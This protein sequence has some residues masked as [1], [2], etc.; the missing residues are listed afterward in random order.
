MVAAG[1]VRALRQEVQEDLI[2]AAPIILDRFPRAKILLIGS[3]WEAGGEA[4]LQR[5]KDLVGTLGLEQSI[6]F[7]GFRNDVPQVLRALD[8]AVQ[9]S[10]SEN[11]GG[12]IELLLMECPTVATCVGGMTDSV[13]DGQTGV[14][15]RP[16]DPR[17]L[18]EGIVK[19]LGNPETAREYG[20]AGRRRMLE[21]F[22]LRRTVDDLAALYERELAKHPAGYRRRVII[23]RFAAGSLLCLVIATR[24]AVRE[25]FVLRFR[26]RA[27]RWLKARAAQ[28]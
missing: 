18:A 14:L 3:G 8:V 25:L 1:I 21:R 9:P 16:A 13:I 23:R 26:D 15:V 22:T 24:Y 17:S 6:V 28:A 2:R 7:T 11:L 12:T 10:L 4:Y 27:A 20:A 19:V 5:M